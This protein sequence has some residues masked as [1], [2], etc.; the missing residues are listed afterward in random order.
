[1]LLLHFMPFA[2][3]QSIS[4]T[5]CERDRS[6]EALAACLV[7]A[8]LAHD[9]AGHFL[10]AF[11]HHALALSIAGNHSEAVCCSFNIYHELL[12]HVLRCCHVRSTPK[13]RTT[14]PVL[15][16]LSVHEA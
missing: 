10:T 5:L 7:Q 4:D 8:A 3:M 15:L 16:V 6:V 9:N 2:I 11:Y 1:M 12:V 14:E 13:H